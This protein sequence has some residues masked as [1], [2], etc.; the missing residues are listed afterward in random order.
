MFPSPATY[1]LIEDTKHLPWAQKKPWYAEWRF[2]NGDW[3]CEICGD[4]VAD[5][6]AHHGPFGRKKGSKWHDDIRFMV[7]SCANCNV[8]TKRADTYESRQ[9]I[10]ADKMSLWGPLF[11]EIV[12]A[13]PEG[14]KRGDRWKEVKRMIASCSPSLG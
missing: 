1:R 10:V 9:I 4:P 2:P 13:A 7:M 3:Q 14:V 6:Q 5:W 12:D 11:V 8:H